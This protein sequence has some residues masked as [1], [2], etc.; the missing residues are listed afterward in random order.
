MTNIRYLNN[1][2]KNKAKIAE[3][4][5]EL[6]KIADQYTATLHGIQIHI[7]LAHLCGALLMIDALD[8]QNA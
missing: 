1:H 4:S 7:A 5:H 2:N 8:K 6:S 3:L